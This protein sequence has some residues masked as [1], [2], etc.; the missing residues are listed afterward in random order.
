M[1]PNPADAPAPGPPTVLVV[2]DDQGLLRLVEK[3]LRREGFQTAAA[4]SGAAALDWLAHHRA[5]LLLLDLK[6]SDIQGGEVVDRLASLEPRTPF[7]IITGQGD[8]RVAVDMMKR[9]A[10][11]YLV[12]DGEFLRFLPQVVRQVL[13]QIETERRLAAAEAQVNL[14]Q[15]V[16]DRG[17]S[18]V[19]IADS[20]PP[21]P[22]VRY[23]NP[24]FAQITGS[25]PEQLV[26]K[27]LSSVAALT[28]LRERFGQDTGWDEKFVDEIA[29]FQTPEGERWGDWRVGP[30]RDR[31]GRISHWLVILR[32]I[33]DRKRL[34][35]EIL[36]ISDREQRRLG[37]DL[38]DGLC[39]Q[40]AGIELMSQVL[41]LKSAARSKADAARAADIARHV[42][43]A[44]AQTRLLA[45][46]LSPVALESEGLMSALQELALNTSAL[47]RVDCRFDCPKPVL[48]DDPGV[49]THLFRIAQEAVSNAIKHGK[50]SRIHVQLESRAARIVVSISDNGRGL[51]DPL[52]PASGMGLRIM[53][54]RAGMIGGTLATENRPEG[55]AQVICSVPAGRPASTPR[56]SRARSQEKNK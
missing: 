48:L 38:H 23:I 4:D 20:G 11:D 33:T 44:I 14:V 55:G 8:E 49:A 32:D 29:R 10:R 34:E 28:G 51:P 12:K 18:A 50:A 17:F 1:N 9:G 15:N 31:S 7:V 24:S 42:R 5:N 47:F 45:R 25:T 6:L 46:G 35:K 27:P 43:D 53:R 41:E 56:Y 36:E 13:E 19:L 30:V 39:Q 22:R 40:L 26:D 3:T 16:I 52:P 21:E 54:S 2:D 37:Q